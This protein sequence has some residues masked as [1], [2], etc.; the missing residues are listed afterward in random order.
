M[1][2]MTEL[3]GWL[4]RGDT[5]RPCVLKPEHKNN[6]RDAVYVEKMREY[7]HEYRQDNAESIAKY[8]RKY[9]QANAEQ[10]AEQ[11]REY[12]QAN[13]EQIAEKSRKYHQANA[14]QIAERHRT[15][16]FGVPAGWYAEQLEK[17]DFKCAICPRTEAGGNRRFHVDHD[18][19]CCPGSKS[20]GLCVRG[21]LCHGCNTGLG[22]FQD[23]S[24][25]LRA[26]ISYLTMYEI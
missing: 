25:L 3:C 20:C 22:Q 9:N 7:W 17:Q 14:E 2:G 11:Q 15:W 4:I 23:S 26:A 8:K 10:I 21:L 19:T 13:A 24:A 1:A 5:A 12:R 18:H 6:H 16:R